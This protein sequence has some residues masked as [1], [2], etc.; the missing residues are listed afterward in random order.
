VVVECRAAVETN[1]IKMS[2]KKS[3]NPVKYFLSGGF[4]GVCTVVAGHPLDTIKVFIR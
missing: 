3:V 2:E 1:S 4:G